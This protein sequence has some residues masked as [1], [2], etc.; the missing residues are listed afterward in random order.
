MYTKLFKAF[1]DES[2]ENVFQKFAREIMDKRSYLEMC[3][4]SDKP[5]IIDNNEEN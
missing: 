2:T 5:A 1:T 3:K 4:N